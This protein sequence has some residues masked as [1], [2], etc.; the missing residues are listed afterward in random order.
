[1]ERSMLFRAQRYFVVIA[2]FSL[3]VIA[4]IDQLTGY[5]IGFF[6][7]YFIP[8]MLGTLG[9]GR[10][11]GLILSFAC[12]AVW[13]GVDFTSAHPYSSAWYPY[14]NA[15]I[16][17]VAFTCVAVLMSSHAKILLEQERALTARL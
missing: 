9:G 14:W 11:A 5:E 2:W 4:I 13:L 15:L 10:I 1:M 3:P 7:F 17:Y 6:V 16:R 12:A 8:V